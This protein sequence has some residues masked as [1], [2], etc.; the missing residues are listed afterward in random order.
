ASHA[1]VA[2]VAEDV[3]RL[4]FNVAVAHVHEF[5]NA[6]GQA[7][8]GVRDGE[9]APD[10]AFALRE[11]AEMLVRTVA[12]MTPHL[13]EE[14]WAAL[15]HEGLVAEAAWP[16]VD[17]ALLVENTITLPI[18][19]NGRKRD[20]IIVP[21]EATPAEIE[22]AVLALE[23]VQRALDGRPP[24]RIIVVPQRIVNVVA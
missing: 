24:K 17:P 8:A 7:I 21:R 22:A 13:A 23:T 3:E 9:V 5:A 6:F 20:D 11:A 19:I 14:C 15:G 18:Q 2:T 16:Q 10:M 4:R 1:L 12:P